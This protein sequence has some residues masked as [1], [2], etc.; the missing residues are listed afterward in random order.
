MLRVLTVSIIVGGYTVNSAR[1]LTIVSIAHRLST[2][3]SADYIYVLDQGHMVE[4][5]TYDELMAINGFF[6]NLAKRQLHT[7]SQS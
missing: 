5:G 3:L 2:I 4:S 6:A 7:P 1:S